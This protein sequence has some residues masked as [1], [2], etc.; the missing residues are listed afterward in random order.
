MSPEPAKAESTAV[1][2]CGLSQLL[3]FLIAIVA[4]SA[5]S[6]L[7]KTMMQLRAV[8]I[9][10]E[11]ELFEKPL[12]Q[13]LGMFVGMLFGLVMHWLVLYFHIPFPGYDFSD[14]DD[15][16]T[17]PTTYGGVPATEQDS[18]IP[19]NGKPKVDKNH[20]PT[21]MYFF[22]IVPSIFDLAATALCMMGLRYINVSIYQMLRGSGIIFVA[23]MKQHVLKDR[24]YRFQWLGIAWNVVS[25]VVIGATALLISMSDKNDESDQ[26]LGEALV[27]VV[28]VLLG[29]FV[30]SLQFVFEEKVMTMDV[31]SPPLLLIGMEG[32]WGTL[33]CLLLLY[34]LAYY[35]PGDDHGSYEDPFNTWCM[36]W[37]SATIQWMFLVYFFAIF[38]Y[39]L[40][41]V[42]VTFMLNSVWH[43]ILD[44]FRPMTVWG[45]DLFI[46][47]A[48][49]ETFG[50]EWTSWSWLQM[51]GMFVLLYGTAIYN[52]PN[53]GS[54]VLK[55][56]WYSLGFNFTPEYEEIE[57]HEEDERRHNEWLNRKASFMRRRSTG[58]GSFAGEWLG[59]Q[60]M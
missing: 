36:F 14:D 38:S 55:G 18:L 41:A 40:F 53:A 7:S 11:V 25:V 20:V 46:F 23:I 59:N 29:A 27:G 3:V 15:D 28:L 51:G 39:N 34:P 60:R 52:A 48:V 8:G 37:N 47:Y 26:Q 2:K 22:L 9:T 16:A 4:G 44:N 42:L 45:A 1:K 30:Q 24:L 21:W 32:F 5:C 57:M 17:L 50:E 13:T 54:L 10:G 43:A 35:S 19:G 49:N 6:I 12:F 56:E 31:S 33:L 58:T